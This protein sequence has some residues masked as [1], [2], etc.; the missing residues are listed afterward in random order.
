MFASYKAVNSVPAALTKA[1]LYIRKHSHPEDLIQDSENDPRFVITGLAERQDFALDC[2]L[3]SVNRNPLE[4]RNR[5]EELAAFKRMRNEA[6]LTEFIRR[7]NI[8]WYI[9]R[10]ESE[11]AWPFSFRQRSVFNSGGYRVYH[12]TP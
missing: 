11:V 8:S 5:L 1:C 9:L 4:L 3:W 10:P 7:H 12:F 6:D 2:K